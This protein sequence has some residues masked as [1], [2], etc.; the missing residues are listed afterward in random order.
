MSADGVQ[1]GRDAGGVGVLLV[2]R[3]VELLQKGNV[4]ARVLNGKL[5]DVAQ[6]LPFA[7]GVAVDARYE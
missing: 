7:E 1:R 3:D 4:I 2:G 5:E 6:G